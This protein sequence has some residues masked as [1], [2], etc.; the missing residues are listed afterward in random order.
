MRSRL[1]RLRWHVGQPAAVPRAPDDLP[2]CAHSEAQLAQEAQVL[3][4]R[5][6]VAQ[7]AVC[8]HGRQ[9][10]PVGRTGRHA[11]LELWMLGFS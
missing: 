8:Q 9:V 5:D 6:Q 7:Q 4:V 2:Q 3:R 1:P 11:S 10:V